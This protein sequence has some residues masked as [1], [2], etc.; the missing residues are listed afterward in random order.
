LKNI[1]SI[2]NRLKYTRII[3]ALVFIITALYTPNL[4]LNERHFPVIPL[5]DSLPYFV[6]PFDY[7]FVI[8]FYIAIIIFAFK[9]HKILGIGITVFY[10]YLAFVD[11][12]RLQPYYYQ[13]ILIIFISSFKSDNIKSKTI[14]LHC[15]MLIFIA[16]Y[17]WSGIHKMNTLFYIQWLSAL[18]KHFDFVPNILLVAFT[19]AVPFLEALMGIFLLF[20]ITRKPAV[21]GIIIMHSIIVIMLFYLGYGFNVVPWN[22]QNILTVIILFWTYTSASPL[23]FLN[24]YFN[25][26]KGLILFMVF[27]LPF[28]NLFNIWDNLLS[29]SFFTSKLNYYYIQINDAA[30][31]KNLPEHIKKYAHPYKETYILY[32]NEWCGAELKVLLY[33][34]DRVVYKVD[35]YLR[36]FADNPNKK[37]ITE[38]VVYNH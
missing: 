13:S 16:T 36:S 11:Q 3:A 15:L 22:A 12:N 30:L 2:D 28:S 4:W 5:C 6:H 25:Y 37:D 8:S 31:Y 19:Y 18:H 38:L 10:V 32:P 14:I 1:S 20:N 29:F 26:K 9:P 27:V 35:T 33:P 23:S 17:F 24:Q 21:V 7:I 34:E